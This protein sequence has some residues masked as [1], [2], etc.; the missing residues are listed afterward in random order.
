MR[1]KNPELMDRIVTYADEFY[2]EKGRSPYI[3]EI[4]VALGVHKSQVARYL[5]HLDEKGVVEYRRGV[6]KTP[7]MMKIA[8]STY[9][10]IVG[11]IPCGEPDMR[12]SEDVDELVSLPVSIFGQGELYILRATGNSM[13][14]AG[15]DDGDLVVVRKTEHAE[16]GDIV[17]AITDEDESTLK[18]L[19]IS[20]GR[21]VLHPENK[22]M[23]DILKPFKIQGV[24]IYVMKKIGTIQ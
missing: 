12:T 10:G 19:A 2:M 21:R 8:P 6:L 23:K 22:T 16:I 11:S 24:A 3:T 13:I 7:M 20:N 1:Q 18:R 14:E 9:T 15:I 17:A 4:S 5:S